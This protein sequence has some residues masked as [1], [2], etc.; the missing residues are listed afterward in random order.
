MPQTNGRPKKPRLPPAKPYDL[1]N[2]CLE[3]GI[4]YAIHRWLKYRDEPELTM[5]DLD[6]LAS[7]LEREILNEICERFE[8]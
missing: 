1:L 3:V 7:Q 8:I 4:Q 2:T 5:T 6:A